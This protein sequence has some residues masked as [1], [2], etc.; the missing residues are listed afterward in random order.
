ML[1]LATMA[2]IGAQLP[3]NASQSAGSSEGPTNG[4]AKVDARS[5][6]PFDL[7]GTWTSLVTQDWRYRM[8]VPRRGDYTGIPINLAAKRFADAWNAATDEAAG[9]QCEA[10]GGAAIMMVPEHLKVDWLDGETLRVH[11]DAGNQIRLLHFGAGSEL[12]AESATRQGTS[13][14]QWLL[15]EAPDP[16]AG[17]NAPP[18]G[19]NGPRYGQLKVVTTGMLPGLLRKNG[20]PYSQ[21]AEVTEYW[22]SHIDPQDQERSLV[23]SAILDDPVYLVEPYVFMAIFKKLSDDTSWSE[24]PC[25]LR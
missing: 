4:A 20:V 5:R 23:V 9:K 17:P 25:S 21:Q 24:A 13:E 6:A 2:F 8:V 1:A 11:T 12:Q 3:C 22:E 10:Y 14:A 18:Q 15:Y 16:G 7:T 19:T